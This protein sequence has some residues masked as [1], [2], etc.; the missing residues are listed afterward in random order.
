M[1]QKPKIPIYSQEA[2]ASNLSVIQSTRAILAIV[3]GISAGVLG[4]ESLWGFGFYFL[5]STL[6]SLSIYI[7]TLG[8][9]TLYFTAPQQLWIQDVFSNLFSYVLFWTLAFGML[10]VY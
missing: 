1:T 10:H 2:Y 4:L 5:I 8:S 9:P 7:L 3:A 6:L